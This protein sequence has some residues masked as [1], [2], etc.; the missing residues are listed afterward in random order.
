MGINYGLNYPMYN[1]NPYMPYG[2]GYG[3]MGYGPR[4]I[5]APSEDLYEAGPKESQE[6]KDKSFLTSA[7][8]VTIG[9]VAAGFGGKVLLKIPRILLNATKAVVKAPFKLMG[10][11]AQGAGKAAEAAAGATATVLN[12][13][14]D[15]AK[16]TINA[17]KP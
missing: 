15:A 3:M 10:K 8:L 11:G 9:L 1:C 7:A 17:V 5:G 14:Q 13:A 12:T 4:V 2:G 16:A 6:S